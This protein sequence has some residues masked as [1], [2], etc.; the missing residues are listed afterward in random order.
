MILDFSKPGELTVD[1]I[2]HIRTIMADMPKD[3]KELPKPL[4]EII[5][6]R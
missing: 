6:S 1:M 2:D 3:M 5:C 4:L